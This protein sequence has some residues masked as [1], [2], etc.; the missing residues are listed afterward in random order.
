MADEKIE[1]LG[2]NLYE[3]LDLIGKSINNIDDRVKTL[4][5]KGTPQLFTRFGKPRGEDILTNQDGACGGLFNFDMDQEVGPETISSAQ[6]LLSSSDDTQ[7]VFASIKDS[8]SKIKLPPALRLTDSTRG[9]K[10]NDQPFANVI[11]KCGRFAETSLKIL[12]TIKEKDNRVSDDTLFELWQTQV[13]QIRFLQEE[14]SSLLVQGQFNPEVTRLYRTLQKHTSGFTPESLN[15]LEKATTIA[16]A[17]TRNN[18]SRDH[19][20]RGFHGGRFHYSNR[21]RGNYNRF[22]SGPRDF[23]RN[24]D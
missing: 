2:K 16:A 6:Q 12:L 7:G 23:I 8:V 13:A 24:E 3:K 14:L 15:L 21:G 20:G 10:R 22:N 4:E 1:E 9:V 18:Y 17:N 5:E 19:R 11:Q